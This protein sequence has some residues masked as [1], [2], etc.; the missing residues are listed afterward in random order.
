MFHVVDFIFV[1]CDE[2]EKSA[3]TSVTQNKNGGGD[4]D[5]RFKV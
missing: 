5:C 3:E 1:T 2:L 4:G